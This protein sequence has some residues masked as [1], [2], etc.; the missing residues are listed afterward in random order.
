MISEVNFGTVDS[1]SMEIAEFLGVSDDYAYTRLGLGFLE[2]HSHVN[3][4]FRRYD[5]KDDKELLDWYRNTEAY[6]W[7]LTAYHL[8]S[9]YNYVGMCHG[10]AQR[11]AN[12][13]PGGSV[14]CLGDGVG[15]LTIV[16]RH[17]GLDPVYHDL[18]SSRTAEFAQFRFEQVPWIERYPTLLSDGW[19]FP[20][21]NKQKF[22]A[23]VSL[24]FLEHV[25]DVPAW[26]SAIYNTLVPGGLFC[27]QNAF[28]CGSGP[29][30]SIPMHLS[31]NDIYEHQWDSLLAS[32]GFVQQ[33]SNW[34]RKEGVMS[35]ATFAQQVT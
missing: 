23:V 29:T 5:P 6:I 31:R 18:A 13:R 4:D 34:Y 15:D 33:S 25:T 27:A 8:D 9:G 22:D 32:L 30:G 35:K 10:I 16:L 28:A 24:D 2:L 3:N 20:Q 11:L 17:C 12:E 1:R 21:R 7:E 19:S 26:A 14:L